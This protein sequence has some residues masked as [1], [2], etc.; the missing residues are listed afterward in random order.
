MLR[1]F[2]ASSLDVRVIAPSDPQR[3]EVLS[4][5]QVTVASMLGALA[6]N[7]A[8]VLIDHGWVRLVGAGAGSVG[9]LHV[10]TLNDPSSALQFEGVLA[11]YDV[12]G[13]RFAIHG[14]GFSAAQPGEVVYWAPDT[15]EWSPLG[16]GHSALVDFMLSERLAQ[17]YE[18]LRWPGWEQDTHTI[19]PDQGLSAYPPPWSEE[20]KGTGVRRAAVPLAEL[21]SHAEDV[22]A[23]FSALGNPN[24][25]KI[26]H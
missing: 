13:G 25:F 4:A 8:M 6:W 17:F 26:E 18:G 1:L 20:G 22:A 14:G 5:L 7:S 9:G 2:E 23:Q 10:E 11:A 12:L 3:Q 21:V 16:L 15:L 19:E 24:Q